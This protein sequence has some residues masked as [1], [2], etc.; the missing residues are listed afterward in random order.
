MMQIPKGF[1]FAVI[2]AGFRSK[3]RND[4]AMA[5]SDRPAVSA[6]TF[7]QNLYPAAPVLVGRERVAARETARAVLVNSGQ[8]N[9]CTGEEGLANCRKTL[10]MAAS[11]FGL[12]AEDILPGSTGVIGPQ[13]L[14]DKW[15]KALPE[16]ARGLGKTDAEGFTRAI[17][18]TDAFPKMAEKGIA[19]EGG[20][21]RLLGVAKGA[22]M[23][24][25][26]MATMLCFVFCDADVECAEWRRICRE[27][28]GLTFNR[29][30]VDGD[31]STNDTM[32]ALANG[33][34]G[35]RV[36]GESLALL[37]DALV[38]V[39]GS[40]AYMLV[41]DGEGA[42]KVA[43][44]TVTGAASEED[45]EKIARTVGHSQLVKTALYGRDANWGRIVAAVG[46][47]GVPLDPN[48]VRVSLCGVE[49]FRNGRPTDLDFDA[50]LEE[51]LKGR[52]LPIDIEVGKGPGSYRLLA[53]DLGHEYVDV[54]ASYRS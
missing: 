26:N 48:A 40:L 38:E 3:N 21:V 34:S 49:L 42:S 6:G 11:A 37:K 12:D 51:P 39:L 45:A 36:R 18:T 10:E 23:I 22:G 54:N 28:V 41:Q 50:L 19:L 9:A 32:Y 13:L 17:M 2:S 24:C 53:S 43:H 52:D 33:A 47:S 27:A 25:P 4:L 8:A 5:V 7:T 29:V 16:L 35:V 30:T 1:S 46:R 20:E 15:E 14:M 44:I 31:T